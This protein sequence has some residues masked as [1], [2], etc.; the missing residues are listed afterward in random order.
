MTVLTKHKVKCHW[1]LEMTLQTDFPCHSRCGM[2][3]ILTAKELNIGL[4]SKAMCLSP[5]NTDC[6]FD[7]IV[8]HKTTMVYRNAVVNLVPFILYVIDLLVLFT[9]VVEILA[10]SN[11][12]TDVLMEGGGNGNEGKPLSTSI[13]VYRSGYVSTGNMI[14]E[15]ICSCLKNPC[16]LLS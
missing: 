7:C 13:A 8:D 1:S 6:L 10:D 16:Y 9:S 3:K 11:L 12:E 2:L 14:A 15:L 4:I 5:S